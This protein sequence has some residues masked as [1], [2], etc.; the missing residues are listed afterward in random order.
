MIEIGSHIARLDAI[1]A[2][3]PTA[4]SDILA[5]VAGFNAD[6]TSNVMSGV[7]QGTA[8]ALPDRLKEW[9][10][11]LV[12]KIREII[13]KLADVTSFNVTVGSPFTVSVSI[14]FARA[15]ES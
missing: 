2:A 1:D 12:A 10:D 8:L 14:T 4:P 11:K 5:A 13:D 6:A 7:Y 9:L 3:S 15:R